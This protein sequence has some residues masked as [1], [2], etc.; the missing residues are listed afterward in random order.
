MP[1]F[2]E[3]KK[4]GLLTTVQDMGRWGHQAMGM[5]VAGA[6]D[7][8]ALA[9]ANV[10]AGNEPEAAALE[11]TL[12]GP[13]LSVEGQGAVAV[14]GEDM[15]VLRGK[16]EA[17]VLALLTPEQRKL[18]E[19]TMPPRPPREAKERFHAGRELVNEWIDSHAGKD[20]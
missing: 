20:S 5:P 4:P 18:W 10:L 13:T 17:S 12:L 15:A 14:A 19:E 2:L 1:L 11:V 3:V 7:P 6:M 8:E 16:V 9:V